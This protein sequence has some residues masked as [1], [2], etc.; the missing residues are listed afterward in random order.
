MQYGVNQII[1]SWFGA[2]RYGDVALRNYLL[3][4]NKLVTNTLRV[5][6]LYESR[7]ALVQNA[8]DN[9]RIYF[10][11]AL[12]NNE[13]RLKD[14]FSYLAMHYFGHAQYL[15]VQNKPVV[16]LYLTRS[17][18]GDFA[19]A[20]GR[21]R[22]HI[23]DTFGYDL[24]LVAGE[25]S[26]RTPDAS[27][28]V[29]IYDAITTYNMYGPGIY[30]GY[31]DDTNFFIDLQAKY[32]EW[33][34]VAN[35]LGIPLIP[36]AMPAY[37]DRGVRLA[38]DNYAWPHERNA[39]LA[40]SGQYSTF[41]ESIRVAYRALQS[42]SAAGVGGGLEPTIAITSWNEWNEDSSIEPTKGIVGPSTNPATYTQGYLY[43]DYGFGHLEVLQTFLQPFHQSQP[44]TQSPTPAPAPAP[45][46]APTPSPT[47]E[48][49]ACSW[50]T[51]FG[52]RTFLHN[53]FGTNH[54]QTDH[55][56]EST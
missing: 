27:R 39:G 42:Q 17:Y 10:D 2:G 46:M 30:R 18:R 44:P 40:G 12:N 47:T 24:Y 45:T 14:D 29:G 37:N 33:R 41:A 55:D 4:S 56:D 52:I 13:Q 20:F 49:A 32:E 22:Q 1:A 3:P 28:F 16:Y 11:N 48:K 35:S 38:D 50:R 53:R 23:R 7:G 8:T 36:Q 51:I 34:L 21:M 54:N 31:P 43:Q 5:C 19:G 6:V 15:R 26:W 9:N 25:V